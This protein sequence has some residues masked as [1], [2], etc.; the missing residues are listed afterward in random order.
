MAVAAAYHLTYED[1][2]GFLVKQVFRSS[3]EAAPGAQEILRHM[4]R[5]YVL[6]CAPKQLD[7]MSEVT[8]SDDNSSCSDQSNPQP[9][10]ISSSTL[11]MKP[12]A[13]NPLEK[14]ANHVAN[15]WMKFE[16]FLNQCKGMHAN[17][18]H[19]K[20]LVDV[21][22]LNSVDLSNCNVIANRSSFETLAEEE[23]PSFIAVMQPV[24]DGLGKMIA[25]LNM[26]DPSKC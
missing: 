10:R 17:S 20:N 15:E 2:H 7:E 21:P 9:S 26:N 4:N 25:D 1:Y 14:L 16:R 23:I 18:N 19:S 8:T 12:K 5:S 3:F 24:L 11:R 13:V 6:P 22:P